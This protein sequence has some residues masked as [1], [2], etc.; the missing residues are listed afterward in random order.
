MLEFHQQPFRTIQ[1]IAQ[2]NHDD[3]LGWLLDAWFMLLGMVLRDGLR[4]PVLPK[5]AAEEG[6]D[7]QSNPS[8]G[9]T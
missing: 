6:T 3:A 9:I 7:N 4:M 8:S 5:P 2:N 1:M